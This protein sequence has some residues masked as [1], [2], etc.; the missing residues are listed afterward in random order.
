MGLERLSL[1][2]MDD[3]IEANHRAADEAWRE[4][5]RRPEAMPLPAGADDEGAW[6]TLAEAVG[7]LLRRVPR[8][9]TVPPAPAVLPLAPG[10]QVHGER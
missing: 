10:P 7:A 5:H 2:L 8:T 3:G 6:T 9:T 1:L 4:M